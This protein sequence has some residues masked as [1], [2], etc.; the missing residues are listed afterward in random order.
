MSIDIQ[1]P[2]LDF[3]AFDQAPKDGE[4][5][6]CDRWW[7]IDPK[8]GYLIWRPSTRQRSASPQCN[9]RRAIT[10]K[11]CADLYPWA[12]VGFAQVVYIPRGWNDD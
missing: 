5:A 7:I 2:R 1:D 9:S 8:R 10:E 6:F 3:I 11:I 4:T 12:E